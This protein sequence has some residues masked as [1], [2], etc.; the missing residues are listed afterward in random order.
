MLKD[1]SKAG[2]MLVEES[3]QP[4]TGRQDWPGSDDPAYK[5]LWREKLRGREPSTLE[6]PAPELPRP[7]APAEAEPADKGERA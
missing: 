1:E 2:E 4:E 7:E 5:Q 3:P 6:R